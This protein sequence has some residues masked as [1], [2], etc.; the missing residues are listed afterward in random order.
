MLRLVQKGKMRSEV[1]GEVRL[2]VSIREGAVLLTIA[3]PTGEGVSVGVTA[4][5]ATQFALQ[6]DEAAEA[7]RRGQTEGMVDTEPSPGA[8]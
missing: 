5:A 2:G 1:V 3:S 6:I 8:V 7:V 4:D